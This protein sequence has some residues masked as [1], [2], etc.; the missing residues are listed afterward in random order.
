MIT[1]LIVLIRPTVLIPISCQSRKRYRQEAGKSLG[2]NE[3][4]SKGG[5]VP[6]KSLSKAASERRSFGQ[7]LEFE[8]VVL[9]VQQTEAKIRALE[10]P[11]PA[12]G[13][14]LHLRAVDTS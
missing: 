10:P 7:Y 9:P 13:Q 3:V 14:R 5:R 6:Q 12:D 4:F 1:L 2:V 8:P 11:E